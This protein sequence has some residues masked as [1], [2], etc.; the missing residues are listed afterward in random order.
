MLLEHA[1]ARSDGAA[2]PQASAVNLA[3]WATTWTV[4]LTGVFF[5]V[6]VR[7]V[8]YRCCRILLFGVFAG[9]VQLLVDI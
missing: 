2:A 6:F 8:A 5:P 9:A 7:L 1:A 4:V 3:S